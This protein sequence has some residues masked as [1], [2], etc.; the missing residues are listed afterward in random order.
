MTDIFIIAG[1]S[2]A[3]AAVGAG[4]TWV[5][6]SARVKRLETEIGDAVE[7]WTDEANRALDYSIRI[8]EALNIIP[9]YK[10]GV[11][12]TVQKIGR[13]LRGEQ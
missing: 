13:I 4:L 3:S 12:G 2:L 7:N 6:Y 1:V 8:L 10:R 5:Y 11:N 9:P